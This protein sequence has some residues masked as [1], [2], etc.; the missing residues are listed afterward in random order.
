MVAA[1]TRRKGERGEFFNGYRVLILQNEKVL[2]FGYIPMYI[3][4]TLLTINLKM[5]KMVIFTLS[6]LYHSLKNYII[7]NIVL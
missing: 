1:R 3:Y 2:Q 7:F 5:A 6:I 4:L